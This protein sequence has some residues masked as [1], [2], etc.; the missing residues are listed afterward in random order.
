M[1]PFDPEKIAALRERLRQRAERRVQ[2]YP[3]PRYDAVFYEG[4]AWLDTLSHGDPMDPIDL[5]L[6]GDGPVQITI[7]RLA[8]RAQDAA[9]ALARLAQALLDALDRHED[10]VDPHDGEAYHPDTQDAVYQAKAD[11][12][13]ALPHPDAPSRPSRPG[14]P[15]P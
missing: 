10:A 5:H 4:V 8:P 13:A 11:L 2:P 9:P 7:R 3:A 15:R 1:S 12:R 6:P 14:Q